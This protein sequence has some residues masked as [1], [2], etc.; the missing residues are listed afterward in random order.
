LLLEIEVELAEVD[1]E[2]VRNTQRSS[3]E[4][5]RNARRKLN[6]W[7]LPLEMRKKNGS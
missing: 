5:S 1:I 6:Q 4:P 2:E 3:R 7:S